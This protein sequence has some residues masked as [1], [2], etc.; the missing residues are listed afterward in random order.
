MYV[1][2]VPLLV[3]EKGEVIKKPLAQIILDTEDIVIEDAIENALEDIVEGTTKNIT[4]YQTEEIFVNPEIEEDWNSLDL[5]YSPSK[6]IDGYLETIVKIENLFQEVVD[7][8]YPKLNLQEQ[9]LNSKI[10]FTS[11]EGLLYKCKES[12]LV[13]DYAAFY[14]PNEGI[15]VSLNSLASLNFIRYA[16]AHE[17]GHFMDYL[18]NSERYT[19][20]TSSMCEVIAI[21]VEEK[22]NFKRR[23]RKESKNHYD[24]QQ[25]LK[26]LYNTNFSNRNFEEQWEFLSWIKQHLTVPF[27]IDNLVG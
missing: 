13:G 25:I 23:Y 15:F 5:P 7:K 16:M 8:H 4:P 21:F 22:L 26:R 27:L 14:K 18:L 9:L 10:Y 12:R 1:Q 20:S 2:E 17:F 3:V 24:A 6:L 11:P 19:N